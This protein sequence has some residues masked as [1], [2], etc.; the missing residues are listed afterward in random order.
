MCFHP[1]I[2]SVNR[3]LIV[4][5]HP[6]FR[7]WARLMLVADGFHVVGEAVDGASALTEARAALPDVV[8]LDVQLPDADGFA[9]AA[10]L[11]A[12]A[13]TR[14]RPV[15]V[16]TSTRDAASYADELARTCLP[17]VPKEDLSG[18]AIRQLLAGRG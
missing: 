3:I 9:V 5:D 10:E 11:L 18:Q 1:I 12:S 17:F 13:G 8:L 2:R 7:A 14:P 4:D 15:I 6:A 16:L